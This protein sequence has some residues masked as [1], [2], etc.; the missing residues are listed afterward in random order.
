MKI[1]CVLEKLKN[2][3]AVVEKVTGKNLALNVLST[4]LLVANGKTLKLRATNLDVG[5]EVEL[6]V[7]IEKE[8][9]VAVKGGIL[10]ELLTNLFD[11]KIV[12][13][14]TAG[15]NLIVKTKNTT[16]TIK[17]SS[18]ADFP[19]IPTI[20]GDNFF[21]IP[22]EKLLT[23][24]KSVSYGAS[25]S[26][27]KPEI[28]AVYIYPHDGELIFVATDSFRLAEKR[29]K[30]KLP[31][32]W[33]GVIIPHRNITEITRVFELME[34]EI[35]IYTSKNQISFSSGGV[36]MTSRL[37]DG[38]FPDYQ[39]IIPKDHLTKIIILKQDLL[40]TLKVSN[41]FLDKFNQITLAVKSPGKNI[42]VSSQS[43]EVGETKT[44]LSANVSGE[45]VEAHLNYRYLFDVFQSITADSMEIL[46]HGA[47]KP[48]ILKGV[49]DN[50][51]TYLIMPLNR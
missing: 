36:Y 41:I 11:E 42:V 7:K 24:I 29:I 27:I 43:G 39:Q 1:E 37:I 21:L 6:P 22:K 46:F 4:I 33:S 2:T 40:N 16:S 10:N 23:G 14:E 32:D 35:K 38:T 44:S 5:V 47:T 3:V 18:P 25:L 9:V 17:S 28:S 26:D 20:V 31:G 15:D 48:L 34:E 8:G 30:A 50:S 13:L 51:F 19:T 49:S 12:I 45:S